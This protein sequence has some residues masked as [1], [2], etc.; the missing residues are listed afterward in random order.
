MPQIIK[1]MQRGGE[2]GEFFPITISPF[3]FNETLGQENYPL[4]KEQIEKRGW[5]YK[6]PEDRI[7]RVEKTI[8]DPSTLPKTINE[9]TEDML[10]WAIKCETSRRPFLIQGREL[11]FYKQRNIPLPHLHPEIRY[12][13]RLE[14]RN[15]FILFP[16]QCDCAE[17]GHGHEGRCKVEFETAYAPDRP[18]KVYCEGCYQ[19]AVI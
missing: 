10:K 11:A 19:K 5:K 9:V 16:H 7:P 4:T 8:E 2:W 13:K 6:E 15:P 18:E 14:I 3:A 1:H 12:Q 17:S